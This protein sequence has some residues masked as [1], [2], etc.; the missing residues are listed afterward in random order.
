MAKSTAD[1]SPWLCRTFTTYSPWETGACEKHMWL[2]DLFLNKFLDV[3]G[4]VTY[5]WSLAVQVQVTEIF[6]VTMMLS[7]V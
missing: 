3:G 5:T 7:A 6:I 4:C 1:R 2:N